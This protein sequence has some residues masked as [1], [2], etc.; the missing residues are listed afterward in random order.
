M[1]GV[2]TCALPISVGKGELSRRNCPAGPIISERALVERRT[3]IAIHRASSTAHVSSMPEVVAGLSTAMNNADIMSL[4]ER[5]Q[6][7]AG[8]FED[9]AD[10][11]SLD[12]PHNLHSYLQDFASSG[13][14]ST[15]GDDLWG[16]GLFSK[17]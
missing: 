15:N 14:F 2:Q 8:A 13:G 17:N 11:A 5:L 12:L 7:L 9:A 4:M 3:P 1:T 6:T 10:P 16:S